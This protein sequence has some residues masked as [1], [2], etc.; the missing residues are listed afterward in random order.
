MV[1]ELIVTNDQV[2]LPGVGTFV[3]EMIPASF[4]DKGYTI[5][6]PYRRLSFYP[7]RLE[8]A[9]L[10]DFYAESNHI[11]REAAQTYLLQFL[12]E[13]KTVLEERKSVVLPGLGRL[14]AT[15]ENHFFFVADES[16]DIFPDGIG[17]QPVSL[18]SHRFQ[19]MPSV[20]DVA[21]QAPVPEP[22]PLPE[23]AAEPVFTAVSPVATPSP[24]TAEPAPAAP[25]PVPEPEQTP[26]AKPVPTT[27]G[28]PA[29]PAEKPAEKPAAKPVVK[30]AAPKKPMPK[31][32]KVIF[33]LL[34]L[35][36]VAFGAFLLLARLAP[37][38]IDPLL[39]TKEELQ[40]LRS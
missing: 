29:T 21:L 3:A 23:T 22:E 32:L 8:D 5:H 17:L 39:Y 36:L 24:D 4:T 26:A 15:R 30:P 28:K 38:L 19:E 34:V 31:W 20:P 25:G 16:L 11:S 7:S 40:I 35:A 1:G 10:I 37:N 13:M 12:S 6:P 2:G 33:L 14:R 9:L 18:K 27:A